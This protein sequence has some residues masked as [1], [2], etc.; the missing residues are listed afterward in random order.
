M[1]N[2][3]LWKAG[4]GTYFD[5]NVNIITWSDEYFVNVGNYTSVGRDCNFFL[6]ANHRPDWITTSTMLLGPVSPEIDLFLME[7]GHPGCKGNITIGNDVWIGAKTTIM[8]GVTIGDGAV[9]GSGSVI[10]KDVP[11]YSIWV[12]NPAKMIK[13]RFSDGQIEK[14]MKIKWWNWP[15]QKIKDEV[16]LLWSDGIDKFIEKHESNIR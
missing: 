9:I 1:E 11:P 13:K 16:A 3:H 5:R 14:L 8:S 2:A 10:A 4:R 7:R 15:E 12:G 6:H